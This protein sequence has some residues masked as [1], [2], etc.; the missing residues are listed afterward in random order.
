MIRMWE[1]TVTS[2]ECRKEFVIR[3][4]IPA[5]LNIG[6]LKSYKTETYKNV[7]LGS[8]MRGLL[9]NSLLCNIQLELD[10][11][12]FREGRSLF[13][14]ST[15]Q[16]TSDGQVMRS[17]CKPFTSVTTRRSA[18]F[19]RQSIA[20]HSRRFISFRVIFWLLSG[21][22]PLAFPP[23]SSESSFIIIQMSTRKSPSNARAR[24]KT[25]LLLFSF[26]KT[27]EV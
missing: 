6:H 13:V 15:S 27:R 8:G 17:N 10:N 20:A 26:R 25:V 12:H 18:L 7:R 16:L 3:S 19:V 9:E 22:A 14:E 23:A 5:G 1:Y 4:R 21:C 11:R 2:I 24:R